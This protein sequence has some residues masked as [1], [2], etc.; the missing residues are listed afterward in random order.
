MLENREEVRPFLMWVL[1]VPGW[2]LAVLERVVLAERCVEG[3]EVLNAGQ[4]L[5]GRAEG[6]VVTGIGKAGGV[7]AAPGAGWL[8][9][10]VG[11]WVPVPGS[12]SEPCE[13]GDAGVGRRAPSPH[14]QAAFVP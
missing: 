1:S 14:A 8:D 5:W 12:P 9:K 6:Q 7:G 11:L 2:G 10:L 4:G 3:W 13:G